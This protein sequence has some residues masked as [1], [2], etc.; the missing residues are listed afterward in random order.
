MTIVFVS[1]DLGL[2]VKHLLPGDAGPAHRFT[3]VKLSVD[4]HIVA[5]AHRPFAAVKELGTLLVAAV[6]PG[7][8]GLF[9]QAGDAGIV[10][11]GDCVGH[12]E[13]GGIDDVNQ[14]TFHCWIQYRVERAS[15]QQL[16]FT[17]FQRIS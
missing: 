10:I 9:E 8:E 12:G 17:F 1:S 2:K 16:F 4:A 15:G 13:L 3:P 11:G 7:G 6:V 14:I 5:H